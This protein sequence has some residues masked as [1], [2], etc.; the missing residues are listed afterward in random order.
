MA[1]WKRRREGIERG[2]EGKREEQ[3]RK[4]WRKGGRK[5][6]VLKLAIML[7]YLPGLSQEFGLFFFLIGATGDSKKENLINHLYCMS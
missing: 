5:R 6:K 7:D 1:E 2:G 3:K 4:R